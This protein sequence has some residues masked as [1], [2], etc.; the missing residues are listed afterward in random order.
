M[1]NHRKILGGLFLAW[2]AL[3]ALGSLFVAFWTPPPELQSAPLPAVYW[4]FM[5]IFVVA[6]AWAGYMNFSGRSE[7]RFL[8]IALSIV[9]LFAFPLGTLLGVYGLWVS[10]RQPHRPGVEP[11]PRRERW[12]ERHA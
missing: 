9:A 10:F 8:T 3:Q 4:V 6:Y 7:V 12:V 1:R 2:A 5:G 11:E